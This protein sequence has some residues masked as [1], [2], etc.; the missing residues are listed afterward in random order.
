MPAQPNPFKAMLRSRKVLLAIAAV[1]STIALHEWGVDPEVWVS[2]DALIGVLIASI[3]YE[4]GAAKSAPVIV[5]AG[6]A[7]AQ[8]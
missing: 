6:N 7:E 1:I 4:D 2:I 8:P 5:E 3:A